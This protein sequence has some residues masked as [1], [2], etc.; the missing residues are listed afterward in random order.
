MAKKMWGGR[1]KKELDKEILSFTSSISFDKKLA[2]CDI[3]GSIAH[4][5]MLG[6]CGIVINFILRVRGTIRWFWT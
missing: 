4:A 1:F 3:N 6:K 5:M 2:H